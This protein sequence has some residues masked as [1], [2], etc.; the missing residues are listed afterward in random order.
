MYLM[1]RYARLF[2][3]SA[4]TVAALGK[5]CWARCRRVE[6]ATSTCRERL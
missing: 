2:W 6:E 1:L 5:P 4:P 3:K